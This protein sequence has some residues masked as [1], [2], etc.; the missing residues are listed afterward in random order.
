MNNLANLLRPTADKRGPFG[1]QA[2]PI[3]PGL[4]CAAMADIMGLLEE[5]VLFSLSRQS[6]SCRDFWVLWWK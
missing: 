1:T 2:H 6:R 4:P 3:E 5:P